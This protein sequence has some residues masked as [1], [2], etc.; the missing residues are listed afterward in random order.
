MERPSLLLDP[1]GATYR[2]GARAGE[3]VE[4]AARVD[5]EVDVD[6][7]LAMVVTAGCCVPKL[8]FLSMSATGIAPPMSALS[9]TRASSDSSKNGDERRMPAR[10]VFRRRVPDKNPRSF[11]KYCV[12][13]MP[14]PSWC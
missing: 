4:F 3:E 6:V 9:R 1:V 13:L 14:K 7:G 5:V 12:S 2:V 10:G 11:E 8:E